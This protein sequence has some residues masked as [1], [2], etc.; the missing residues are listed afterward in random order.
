M[1]PKEILFSIQK[2]GWLEYDIPL[3]EALAGAAI[4]R[5]ASGSFDGPSLATM[6]RALRE[7]EHTDKKV[8]DLPIEYSSSVPRLVYSPLQTFQAL[9]AAALPLVS[10]CPIP[11]LVVLL[12]NLSRAGSGDPVLFTEAASRALPHLSSM[13]AH[14]HALLMSSFAE[15]RIV[16]E[17]LAEGIAENFI[18]SNSESLAC[19]LPL[20]LCMAQSVRASGVY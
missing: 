19:V 11:D 14:E 13:T 1:S 16:H 7:A 12:F 8:R 10:S 18:Q 15:T 2:L 20:R 6:I 17:L 9:S 3:V 5:A 4:R